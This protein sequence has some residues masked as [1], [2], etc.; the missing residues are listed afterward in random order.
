MD[1][2]RLNEE[3]IKELETLKNLLSQYQQMYDNTDDP[4]DKRFLKH[5]SYFVTIRV[6]L[7]LGSD[8]KSGETLRK[9]YDSELWKL[10]NTNTLG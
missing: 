3:K 1:L 5:S 7:L 8:V 9:H 10:L 6:N 4:F 2:F